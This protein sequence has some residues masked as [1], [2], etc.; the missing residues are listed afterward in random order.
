MKLSQKFLFYVILPV[1][2]MG[3]FM[4]FGY[5]QA[6]RWQL[7]RFVRG[8][9]V[10]RMFY[11]LHPYLLRKRIKELEIAKR[12]I[13]EKVTIYFIFS[14]TVSVGTALVLA[15][16]FQ[17]RVSNLVDEISDATEKMANG[18]EVKIKNKSFSVE[19]EKLTKSIETLSKQLKEKSSARRRITSSVYHELMT[20]LS[21]I[22][23]Q[24]E[25]LKDGMI[26]Y[27][28][29][30]PSN[31]IKNLDHISQVLKDIKNIEGGEIKYTREKFNSAIICGE[32]CRT[33]KN[34]FSTRNIEFSC[35][36]SEAE[37]VSDEQR[38]RQ[39]IF[40][41]LSNA[42]KYTP[43]GGKVEF[44]LDSKELK[45]LNTSNLTPKEIEFRDGLNFVKRFCE[46]YNW[47]FGIKANNGVV[48]VSITFS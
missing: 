45:I 27:N 5:R 28:E 23:M 36:L 1:L 9:P 26:E 42:L 16:I 2:M 20:P 43:S 10:I 15:E 12:E 48:E 13:S 46:S 19:F 31:M 17:R 41:L 14:L 30:L 35:S 47:K 22:R 33:F 11:E 29:I 38:F 4:L 7:N 25:A 18:E 39:A 21:V 34:V 37:I 8:K 6:F 44:H 32:L 3:V 40:N 24:L